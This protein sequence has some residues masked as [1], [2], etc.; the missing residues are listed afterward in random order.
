M[1]TLHEITNDTEKKLL[2]EFGQCCN[3]CNRYDGC[4]GK[5]QWDEEPV[6]PTDGERC[7]MFEFDEFALKELQRD[8]LMATQFGKIDNPW[9]DWIRKVKI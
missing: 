9:K 7:L 2:E 8:H 4:E 6:R 5:C 1:M 3:Y